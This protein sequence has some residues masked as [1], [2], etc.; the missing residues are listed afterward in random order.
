MHQHDTID[1]CRIALRVPGGTRQ[2][3]N[4]ELALRLV[5]TARPG[6]DIQHLEFGMLDRDVAGAAG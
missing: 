3:F 2:R 4:K 1:R 6:S 5:A